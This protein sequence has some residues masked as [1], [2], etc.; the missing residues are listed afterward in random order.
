MSEARI[1]YEDQ[2]PPR[3]GNLEVLADGPNPR[4][5]TQ[6]DT[7]R[8]AM[9]LARVGMDRGLAASYTLKEDGVTI[10]VLT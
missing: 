5:A 8:F 6:C 10:A 7:V 4:L 9:Q 2:E 1:P 3:T